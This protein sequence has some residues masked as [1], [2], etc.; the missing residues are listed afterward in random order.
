MSRLPLGAKRDRLGQNEV[1]NGDKFEASERHKRATFV[2][3]KRMWSTPTSDIAAA[4]RAGG[5]RRH[6]A[7]RKR[8]MWK[9]MKKDPV[10]YER[11]VS[12]GK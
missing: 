4:R 3:S 1:G 8:L 6:N 12:D 7:I 2:M 9:R 10:E 5:R 11:G